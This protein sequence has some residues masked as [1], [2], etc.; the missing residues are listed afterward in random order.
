M[1]QRGQ[2]SVQTYKGKMP[3]RE[4]HSCPPDTPNLQRQGSTAWEPTF[5]IPKAHV[6]VHEA[7]RPVL[8]KGACMCPD[9]WPNLG[10]VIID[11]DTYIRSA[12]QLEGEQ[13][14]HIPYVGSKLHAA[15]SAPQNSSSSFSPSPPIPLPLDTLAHK[16]PLCGEGATTKQCTIDDCPHPKPLK[17]PD[18]H[19]K[20]LEEAGGALL[21]PG[22][23]P[24][25]LENIGPFGL[26]GMTNKVDAGGVESL[27][28][29]VDEQGGVSSL[30]GAVLALAK[31]TTSVRPAGKAETA[32][33][34]DPK[35]LAPWAQDKARRRHEVNVL[36]QE[37]LLQKGEC[38]TEVLS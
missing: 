24:V 22:N 21:T 1:G 35:A 26:A 19:I 33:T 34:T 10:A 5:A 30:M 2:T 18:L 17:L 25:L 9:P 27:G 12:L 16:N 31:G 4:V 14:F 29:D 11:P 36:P 20:V 15:P 37:A 23:S 13:N 7:Q 6:C 3:I 8:D 32:T 38:N 28:I